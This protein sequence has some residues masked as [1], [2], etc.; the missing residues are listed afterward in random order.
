MSTDGG[1]DVS[2]EKIQ[3]RGNKKAVGFEV[4]KDRWSENFK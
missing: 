4:V 1:L 3:K 2:M